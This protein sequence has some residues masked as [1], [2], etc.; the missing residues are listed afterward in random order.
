MWVRVLTMMRQYRLSLPAPIEMIC[1]GPSPWVKNAST[2]TSMAV[3]RRYVPMLMS[4]DRLASTPCWCG[5]GN[6]DPVMGP[7]EL[8]AE[9]EENSWV[10]GSGGR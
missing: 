3:Q 2:S 10:N 8:V 4:G 1:L 9:E 7:A 6:E 5:L